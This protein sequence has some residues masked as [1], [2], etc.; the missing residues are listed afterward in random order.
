MLDEDK[1]K[2]KAHDCRSQIEPELCPEVDEPH[3]FRLFPL[4]RGVALG[5]DDTLLRR[6][7]RLGVS[8]SK[9]L[10]PNGK[11]DF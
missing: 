9:N 4:D 6:R 7:D 1:S 11:F 3:P 2:A 8:G 10:R 5:S